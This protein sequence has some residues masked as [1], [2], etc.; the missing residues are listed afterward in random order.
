MIEA[1]DKNFDSWVDSGVVL[2]D[3][4]APWCGPCRALAPTL[5]QLENVNVIKVDVDTNQEIAKKFNVSSIPKLVLMKDGEIVEEMVG[6][7]T[8]EVLQ[9]KI[10]AVNK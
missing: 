1:N 10:D 3:F 5:S 6:L 7:Q 9:E 2:I 8:K 4:Y